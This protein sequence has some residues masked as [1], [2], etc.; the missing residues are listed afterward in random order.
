[1]GSLKRRTP[2][3]VQQHYIYNVT[4]D[5]LNNNLNNV[6][7]I[8]KAKQLQQQLENEKQIVNK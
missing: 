7:N 6:D 2:K 3:P 4:E 8:E 5:R 1:L